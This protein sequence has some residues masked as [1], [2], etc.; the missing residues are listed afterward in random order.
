M[1]RK[2]SH[3]DGQNTFYYG[4]FVLFYDCDYPFYHRGY[5]F[6]EIFDYEEF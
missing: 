1:L 5:S 3:E 6:I 2:K 4:A